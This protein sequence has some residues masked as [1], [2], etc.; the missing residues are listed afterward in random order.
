MIMSLTALE[1]KVLRDLADG[2]TWNGN[3]PLDFNNPDLD[4]Q[5]DESVYQTGVDAECRWQSLGF[6]NR[7]SYIAVLGS[8]KKKGCI[9]IW[10]GECGDDLA[11]IDHERFENI[12]K[13][14]GLE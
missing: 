11:V 6:K 13:H 9:Y 8:L 7:F 2:S 1:M 14:L 5:L 12:R 10:D 4:S 3:G